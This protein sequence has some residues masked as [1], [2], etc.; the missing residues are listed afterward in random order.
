MSNIL[1]ILIDAIEIYGRVVIRVYFYA[2][3]QIE[4]KKKLM[5][6][7]DRSEGKRYYIFVM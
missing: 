1:I 3:P 6:I 2:L 5:D 7:K 4:K